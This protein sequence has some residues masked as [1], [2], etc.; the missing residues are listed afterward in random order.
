M[1]LIGGASPRYCNRDATPVIDCKSWKDL[2]V[3]NVAFIDLHYRLVYI[4]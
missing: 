3:M 2:S 1:F 4:T